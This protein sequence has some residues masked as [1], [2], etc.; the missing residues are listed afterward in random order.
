MRAEH[1]PANQNISSGSV[2]SVSIPSHV[3]SVIDP[4][5]AILLDVKHGKYFSLNA[6]AGEIWL[7]LEAGVPIPAIAA[8]IAGTYGVPTETVQQDL[9]EFVENL[10]RKKVIDAG[11]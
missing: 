5:G 8:D 4:D 7:K 3:R 1:Q 10:R 2:A 9:R 6:V 11:R